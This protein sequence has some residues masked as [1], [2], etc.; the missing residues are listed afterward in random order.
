MGTER[1]GL[2]PNAYGKAFILNTYRNSI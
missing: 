2:S 1:A